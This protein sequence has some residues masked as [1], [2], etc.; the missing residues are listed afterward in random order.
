MDAV[1]L[2]FYLRGCSASG[3]IDTVEEDANILEG[4]TLTSLEA[5]LW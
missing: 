1:S 2:G 5:I 3:Q 4:M